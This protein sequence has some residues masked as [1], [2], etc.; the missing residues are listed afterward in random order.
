MIGH[1]LDYANL[2][3]S[4]GTSSAPV[5]QSEEMQNKGKIKSFVDP[6]GYRYEVYYSQVRDKIFYQGGSLTISQRVPSP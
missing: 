5:E 3:A 6:F 4:A 1:L 2:V